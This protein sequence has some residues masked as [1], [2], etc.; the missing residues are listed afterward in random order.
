MFYKGV[1]VGHGMEMD[2]SRGTIATQV[3]HIQPFWLC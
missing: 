1:R 2:S 3:I